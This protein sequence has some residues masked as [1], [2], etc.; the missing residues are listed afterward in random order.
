VTIEV[1]GRCEHQ[2]AVNNL[3]CTLVTRH[4]RRL[5]RQSITIYIGVVWQ[6]IDSNCSVF[7]C[8]SDIIFRHWRIVDRC[9]IDFNGG[10]F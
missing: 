2:F 7:L 9:Y 6:N 1:F 3:D 4:R 8:R 5:D 10:G